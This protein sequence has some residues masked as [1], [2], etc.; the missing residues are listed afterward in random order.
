MEITQIRVLTEN[1]QMKDLRE[2]VYISESYDQKSAHQE[3]KDKIK[4]PDTQ[5]LRLTIHKA[6]LRCSKNNITT[7]LQKNWKYIVS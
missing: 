3:Q 7:S 5:S 6:N 4:V 1:V 2:G